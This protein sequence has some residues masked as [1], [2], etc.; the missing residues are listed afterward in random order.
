MRRTLACRSFMRPANCFTIVS[1]LLIL[2][3]NYFRIYTFT[4]SS[5]T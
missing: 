1:T 3:H 5:Y 2:M 4:C